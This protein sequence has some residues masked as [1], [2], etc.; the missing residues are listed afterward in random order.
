MR[1]QIQG[2]NRFEIFVIVLIFVVG[3]FVPVL[4]HAQVAG[5]T[6]SG[7][8]TDPSNSA[9]PNSNIS[10]KN[11]DTGIAR[12]ITTN[13]AGFYN[14]PNLSPGIYEVSATAPGF[15]K[16]VQTNITLSVGAQ[17]VLNLSLQVG[18]VSQ[19]VD[20]VSDAPTVE[21]TSSA[22][23]AEVNSLTVRELPLNGRDWSSLGS[24]PAWNDRHPNSAR[25]DRYG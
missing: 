22:I 8:V 14:V 1:F 9:V 21:L 20:V 17:Q 19:T 11:I 16:L 25:D 24:S 12:D 4:A 15:S 2:R 3:L 18:E 23:P 10:I 13:D 6:L 7:T 5:A